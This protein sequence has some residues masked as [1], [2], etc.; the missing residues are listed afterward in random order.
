M[1]TLRVA[2]AASLC[3]SALYG[4]S[5]GDSGPASTSSSS[6]S[7][8]SSSSSGAS[9]SGSGSSGAAIGSIIGKVFGAAIKYP[10]GAAQ[11]A[12]SGVDY[13]RSSSG[14][15][16]IWSA[17]PIAYANAKVCVDLNDNGVCDSGEN[18]ATTG[19]DGTFTIRT[20]QSGPLTAIVGPATS[21]IDPNTGTKSMASS[22]MILRAAADQVAAGAPVMVS[23]LSGE[24][25]RNME[26]AELSY[27]D[28]RQAIATR[29][30]L[31][32][33]P[34]LPT[35]VTVGAD[36][37][38]ADPST[39][40]DAN[41]AG[42]LLFET[43][44]LQNRQVLATTMLQR[45]YV[46]DKAADPVG[47]I[48]D[49]QAGAFNAEDIPR[50]D[51]LFVVIF[52][53]HS[54]A[55]IDSP[56]YKNFYSYLHKQGN[57]AANYFST[58]NP[59]EPN[60]VALASADTWGITNDSGWNCMPDGD[61]ADLPTDVYNP[62]GTCTDDANHNQ[63]G[64]R[65]LFSA[66]YQAGLGARV[67]S[68]SM[69]P[70]QDPRVDSLGNPAITAANKASGAVEPMISGLYKT[71]HH[72][73]MYF[74]EVRNRPDFFRN[75]NRTVG[76]GQWDSAVDAYAKTK[77]ISW[78]THQLEDDLKSGDVGALNFIVPDQCDDIHGTGTAVK[79]CT[80]GSPGIQRGDAYGKYLVDTIQAS[81]IWKNSA[82][83]VG[84][85]FIFDEGSSF[86]GSSSCCGWN[87]GGDDKAGGPLGEGIT[88]AAPVPAYSAGNKGDGPTIFMV[89]N[90]QPTA[91]KGIYD[92]D[93]YSHFSFNRTLQDMFALADPGDDASYMN[94]SKYTEAFIAANIANL[95]E[96][97]GSADTHFDAVRPMNH[98]YV[99]K[100]G[101][102]ISGGLLPGGSGSGT[103]G[104][105]L[106]ALGPDPTQINIWVFK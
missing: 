2:A 92:S 42:A 90:N 44:A 1:K 9:S 27:A 63:K 34:A 33:T 69:D 15:S 73:A 30:S 54:N 28:A 38:T 23:A 76:G 88:P 64:R 14:D 79:N 105:S 40:S 97:A 65:N 96:Y 11:S 95:A 99:M 100:A 8:S 21:Y 46:S 75:L 53:N 61:T 103:T 32:N 91:P 87:V 22:A 47:T 57:K 67:Y 7:S 106:F 16:V 66:L 25:L 83:K 4:C 89:M 3:V 74:D 68:E 72:P 51:Q 60:Y 70:G 55:T 56:I 26:S 45:G 20:N 36:Q 80:S 101:D 78:N 12:A 85:V 94:R 84:I 10:K 59:S 82:R 17:L 29:L 48:Q 5:G 18:A 71:K 31:N 39:L 86:F 35:D 77:G 93:T 52:E 24:V 81:P 43:R 62:R 19:G 104:L 37:V 13:A 41:A 50:Y 102:R 6:G 58:G 98:H 49:A